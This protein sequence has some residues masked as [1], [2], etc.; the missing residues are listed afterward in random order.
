[1][2]ARSITILALLSAGIIL[3][4]GPLTPPAGFDPKIGPAN[5][6]DGT[7]LPQATMKTLH[8][9]EPRTPLAA[10][11]PG[12]TQNPNGGFTITA[13]GSYY[14]TAGF[15]VSTGSGISVEADYVKLDLNGMNIY[16]NASPASGAG[17]EV[18][19]FRKGLTVKNGFIVGL[20]QVAGT[21]APYSYTAG[22]FTAGVLSEVTGPTGSVYSAT[23][24]NLDVRGCSDKGIWVI[25][26]RYRNCFVDGCGGIGLAG[27]MATDCS[28]ARCGGAYALYA[29]VVTRCQ[30]LDNNGDG[31][32]AHS[33]DQSVAFQNGSVGFRADLVTNCK[34][35]LNAQTGIIA[36]TVRDCVATDNLAFGIHAANVS[37]STSTGNFAT[38]ILGEPGTG[39]ISNCTANG[40]D[41]GILG[42]SITAC[43]ANANDGTGI[44]G[45]VVSHC[46]STDN[47]G[48][49][50][51]SIGGIV[52]HCRAFDNG[53]G[54]NGIG[55]GISAQGSVI[56]F[57][58]SSG[59]DGGRNY[60]PAINDPASTWFSN[61]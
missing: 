12:V 38:G 42:S 16:S 1:M 18:P 40:N 3:A 9:V 20:T 57:S 28:V 48:S 59:N 51:D 23:L 2:K 45:T 6:L 52:D 14:L 4:Q 13:P 43:L 54:L 24:E 8:Q 58:V 60:S 53:H 15:G 5:A 22:G 26:G 56:S 39:T 35:E 10:G 37:G 7:G 33:V 30:V 34:A 61:R 46:V 21:A 11:Q 29:D 19:L 32:Q 49:G 36:K 25:G 44:A 47:G 17:V 41:T 50:I 27:A 55:Y 31:I